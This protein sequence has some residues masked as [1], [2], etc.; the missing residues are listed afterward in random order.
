MLIKLLLNDFQWNSPLLP[1]NV[2]FLKWRKSLNFIAHPICDCP[3]C[4][5]HFVHVQTSFD[6]PQILSV[7]VLIAME[8][9]VSGLR[10]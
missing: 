4:L 10:C 3:S 2:S 1:Y 6:A 9:C 7:G 8:V 5:V